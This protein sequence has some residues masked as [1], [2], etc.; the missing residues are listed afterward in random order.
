MHV[1]DQSRIALPTNKKMN[2]MEYGG[3]CRSCHFEE[4]WS[5]SSGYP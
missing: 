5:F 4:S 1:G 3:L 2:N